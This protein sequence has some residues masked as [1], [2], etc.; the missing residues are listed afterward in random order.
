MG[1]CHPCYRRYQRQRRLVRNCPT[2]LRCGASFD[3]V[4]YVACG[5]CKRCYGVVAP[6]EGT[7][8][9]SAELRLLNAA[10]PLVRQACRAVGASVVAQRLGVSVA[11]VMGW[12]AGGEV[13]NEVERMALV[14]LAEAKARGG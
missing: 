10:E 4:R 7:S 8:R 13:S 11:V 3:E 2:C 1:L 12:S 5:L 9:Y 14:L 6:S